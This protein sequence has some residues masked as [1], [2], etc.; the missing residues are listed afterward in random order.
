M[1]ANEYRVSVWG[2]D[3]VLKLTMV[4]FAQFC[5]YSKDIALYS[6]NGWIV[7]ELKLLKKYTRQIS[8]KVGVTVE[9]SGKANVRLKSIK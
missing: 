3:S 4:M 9:I 8:K 7:C 2:D 5:E 1:T 6:L